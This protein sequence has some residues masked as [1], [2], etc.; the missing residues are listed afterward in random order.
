LNKTTGFASPAQG[1]E[2]QGIDLSRLLVNNPAATYYFRLETSEMEAF[3]LPRGSLLIVD[4]SI[5][6][7]HNSFALIRHD[8]QF[9]CRL[10]TKHNNK[11]YF[12]NGIDEIQS[13]NGNIEIIG[14]V[15]ASIKRY[16]NDP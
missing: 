3:N 9:L 15:T 12:T 6:P 14:V 13:L 1:Y 8:G 11:H 16:T 10:F 5:D 2:E 4:R 7:T